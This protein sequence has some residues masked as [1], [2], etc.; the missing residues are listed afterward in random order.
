M[1]G[2]DYFVLQNRSASNKP[3]EPTASGADPINKT[4]IG[5]ALFG[6][7]LYGLVG[8]G[9]AALVLTFICGLVVLVFRY[10]F[11]I[12]LPFGRFG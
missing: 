5:C 9:F 2:A 1:A 12:E 10:V 7:T 8:V 6:P 3:V 4:A 11:G